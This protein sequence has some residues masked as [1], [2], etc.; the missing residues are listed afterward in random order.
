MVLLVLFRDT[1]NYVL[2]VIIYSSLV[3]TNQGSEGLVLDYTVVVISIVLCLLSGI[4]KDTWLCFRRPD[5]IFKIRYCCFDLFQ[6][7]HYLL[8]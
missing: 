2:L 5:C 7:S 4:R 1:I 6:L 3:S 8:L